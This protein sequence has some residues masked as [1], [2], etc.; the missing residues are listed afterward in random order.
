MDAI[1]SIEQVVEGLPHLATVLLGCMHLA[2]LP[3]ATPAKHSVEDG[4][5]GLIV[6]KVFGVK[7]PSLTRVL[8]ITQDWCARDE[9]KV[10]I[11]IACVKVKITWVFLILVLLVG[12]KVPGG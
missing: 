10:N 6:N 4:P 2:I 5:Y 3:L 11:S 9:L 12:V 1:G 8:L 7:P